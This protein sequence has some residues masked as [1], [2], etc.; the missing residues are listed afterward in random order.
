MEVKM[1]KSSFILM[2]ALIIPGIALAQK[3]GQFGFN[4]SVNSGSAIGVTYHL[5]D[6]FALRP[7]LSYTRTTFETTTTYYDGFRY[8]ERKVEQTDKTYG[9]GLEGLLY[10]P[11][12]NDFTMYLGAGISYLKTERAVPDDFLFS[13]DF[14]TG[15]ISLDGSLGLQ[16]ALS[17]NLSVYGEIGFNY[18]DGDDDADFSVSGLSTRNSGIGIILYLK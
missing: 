9:G 12:S 13:P 6:R 4:L 10:F 1:K 8:V 5:S 11:S 15:N 2:L 14:K 17:K 18:I 16:Y 7:S 3:K